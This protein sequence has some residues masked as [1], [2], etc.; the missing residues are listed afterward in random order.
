MADYGQDVRLRDA[1]EASGALFREQIASVGTGRGG[2][3]TPCTDWTV[4]DLLNHVVGGELRYLLLLR[5]ASTDE[6]EA[7]RS[8]R[9]VGADPAASFDRLHA[10]LSAA[11]LAPGALERVVHHRLGDRLGRDLLAMRVAEYVLHGWDLASACGSDRVPDE[12]LARVVLDEMDRA[13]QLW[14]G[15]GLFAPAGRASSGTGEPGSELLRRT[16]RRAVDG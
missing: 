16:G 5:G 2:W 4:D 12:Q 13:P 11:F 7:T 1:F 9:H 3:P 8:V 14:A 10:E 6:V 15:P